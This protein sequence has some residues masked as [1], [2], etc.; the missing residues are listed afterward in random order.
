MADQ[1]KIDNER[2]QLVVKDNDLIQKAKYN[3]TATEQKLI[4][5]VISKIKPTDTELLW[6]EISVIDYCELCGITKDKFYTE[7]KNLIS[8]LND[9]AI[10]VDWKDVG[11]HFRWFSEAEY[12]KGKGILRVKLN[13]RLQ[14]YLIGLDKNFTKYELI[15]I[16]ALKGKFAIRLFELFKSYE[17]KKEKEFETEEL[18]ELL[19]ATNWK[20]FSDFRKFVIERATQEINTYTDI[21]VSYKFKKGAR[22]KVVSI[23]FF[24]K[25]KNSYD[26]FMSYRKTIEKI[27]KKNKQIKGQLSIFDKTEEDF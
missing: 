7:F 12:L 11:F 19:G 4:A 27:N 9:K 22:G 16:L 23:V 8:S 25:K 5:Y 26:N 14:K 6:Y 3:L 13:S 1:K 2:F 20:T 15:N 17:Y 24:I 21:D 18:K 10:W